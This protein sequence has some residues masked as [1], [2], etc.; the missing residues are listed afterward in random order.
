MCVFLRGR[1]ENGVSHGRK[2]LKSFLEVVRFVVTEYRA[3]GSHGDPVYVQFYRFSCPPKWPCLFFLPPEVFPRERGSPP[4]A[5]DA[6]AQVGRHALPRLLEI[7][8]PAMI[9]DVTK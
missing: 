3:V 6:R 4:V 8:K 7:Q 1:V 5:R 9:W 2:Y